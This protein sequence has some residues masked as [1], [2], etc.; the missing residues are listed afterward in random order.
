MERN[1]LRISTFTRFR[2][3]IFDLNVYSC[4]ANNSLS[5]SVFFLFRICFYHIDV[6]QIFPVPKKR[7]S[8]NDF[9]RKKYLVRNFL[10]S[11]QKFLPNFQRRVHF[12]PLHRYLPAP[13]SNIPWRC[14]R[15]SSIRVYKLANFSFREKIKFGRKLNWNRGYDFLRRFLLF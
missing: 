14:A 2:S 12:R 4:H 1:A 13:R 10:A 3:V 9:D 7:S 6:A 11:R 5:L 15:L 8:S